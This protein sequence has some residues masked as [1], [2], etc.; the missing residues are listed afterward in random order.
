MIKRLF[1]AIVLVLLCAAPAVFAGQASTSKTGTF[2]LYSGTSKVGVFNDLPSC[3]TAALATA[4][5][6]F[7]VSGLPKQ[8]LS[9][10]CRQTTTVTVV[11]TPSTQTC[12][13]GSVIASTATC[14]PAHTNHGAGVP[15]ADVQLWPQIPAKGVASEA[16]MMQWID[17][18]GPWRIKMDTPIPPARDVPN[19][20]D[21]RNVASFINFNRLDPIV[22]PRQRDMAHVHALFGLASLSELT[23]GA[24]IRDNCVSASRGGTWICSAYWMPAMIDSLTG[25]PIVPISLL[26]YYKGGWSGYMNLIK[27][28]V[29]E[30]DT[31]QSWPPG[32]VM[33]AGT[34]MSVAPQDVATYICATTGGDAAKKS[35]G[36]YYQAQANIPDNCPVPGTLLTH[37]TF[38]Q[39][40]DGVNLD[41]VDHKSHMAYPSG[42]GALGTVT[43]PATHPKL[44]PRVEFIDKITL[45]P[46]GDISKWVRSSDVYAVDALGH[47]LPGVPRGYSMHGD[48]MNGIDPS[49][50]ADWQVH[51]YT[52]RADCGSYTRG[53]GRTGGEFGD[54]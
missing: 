30:G 31:I 39:C 17:P 4:Q 34:A 43:C 32:L 21:V 29:R 37:L 1:I 13:D 35:D 48:W 12:W 41:S 10:G 19:E 27:N 45:P 20:G 26:V 2:D 5:K 14:P 33:I 3:V 46:D 50:L 44:L 7:G 9:Y 22:Y 52:P 18:N 42:E 6:T 38:P 15:V 28:G 8:T 25:I 16:P 47:V 49:V 11:T 53:D 51:C 54:N 36:T 40:W 23:T 24:N